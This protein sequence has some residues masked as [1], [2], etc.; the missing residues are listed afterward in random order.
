MNQIRT[1]KK[2]LM[3]DYLDQLVGVSRDLVLFLPDLALGFL[4]EEE[5]EEEEEG[6][7]LA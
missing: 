6:L 5:E 4:E 1:P 3:S 2:I 7:G